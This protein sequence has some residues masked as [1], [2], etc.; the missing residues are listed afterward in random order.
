MSSR[1]SRLN[2]QGCI[3]NSPCT[4]VRWVPTSAT[5]FLVSH[6]DGTI[7]VYDK[8]REDGV[9]TPQ[10]PKSFVASESAS[11]TSQ[12]ASSP[13]EWNPL[14]NMFVT[15]PP[16]HPAT[17]GGTSNGGRPDKEK[18]AKNPV[19]HWRV[20]RR[21]VVGWYPVSSMPKSCAQTT[22]DFIFSPDVKY[23]AAISED[24]C[25]RLIDALAEQYAILL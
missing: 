19:S 18:A 12:E 17:G 8:E 7:I 23:V 6:A 9:F 24:G 2:K 1:Y 5:L 25:L 13:K 10:D 16:W 22:A 15:V 20:S 4:A 3:S 14:D 11:P 21:S